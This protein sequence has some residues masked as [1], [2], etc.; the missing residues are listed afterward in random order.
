MAVDEFGGI[1]LL[2]ILVLDLNIDDLVS[3]HLPQLQYFLPEEGVICFEDFQLLG[4]LEADGLVV[5]QL[6]LELSRL[7]VVGGLEL[8]DLILQEQRLVGVV[9]LEGLHLH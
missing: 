5:G 3:V 8:G 6:V 2:H 1:L 7:V 4:M 9:P